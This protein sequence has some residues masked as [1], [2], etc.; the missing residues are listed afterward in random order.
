MKSFAIDLSLHDYE[1]DFHATGQKT[2]RDEFYYCFFPHCFFFSFYPRIEWSHHYTPV[3]DRQWL[4]PII[5]T[6]TSQLRRTSFQ[7]PPTTARKQL[8]LTKELHKE[9][10]LTKMRRYGEEAAKAN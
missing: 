3:N 5:S 7:N 2:K 8:P 10:P 9:L 4:L 1:E 6:E